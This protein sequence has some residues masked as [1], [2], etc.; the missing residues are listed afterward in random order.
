MLKF[1]KIGLS[2]TDLSDLTKLSRPTMYKYL[3]L[4][5]SGNGAY[6]RHDLF[7]LLEYL[8]NND[9]I[10]KDDVYAFYAKM[11]NQKEQDHGTADGN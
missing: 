7:V 1:K 5:V 10:T 4:Y 8:Q 3:D 9:N 6:I 2:I 11:T